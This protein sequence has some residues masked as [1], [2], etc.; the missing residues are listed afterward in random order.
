MSYQRLTSHPI[1]D[2]HHYN[3]SCTSTH[4]MVFQNFSSIS[5]HLIS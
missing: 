2:L 4:I 3:L 1:W 5:Y